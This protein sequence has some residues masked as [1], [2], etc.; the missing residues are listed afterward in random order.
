MKVAKRKLELQYL[1]LRRLKYKD[2]TYRYREQLKVML[3]L[4]NPVELFRLELG[5]NNKNKYLNTL[6]AMS[7]N[8]AFYEVTKEELK[9]NV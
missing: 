5:D 7:K 2:N 9:L 1:Q 6:L 8:D 3:L 4:L